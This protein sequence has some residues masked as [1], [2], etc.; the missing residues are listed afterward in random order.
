MFENYKVYGPYLRYDGRKHVVLVDKFTKK[1][2]TMSYPKYLYQI[3]HNVI[4]KDDQTIDHV[5][6][7]F[8][9]DSLDNLVV[10]S[11]VEHGKLDAR[12]V[13]L[14][15]IECV[16]CGAIAHK[17]ARYLTHSSRLG[18]AGPFCGKVCSGKYGASVQNGGKILP[19][20]DEVPKED[21]EYFYIEK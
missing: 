8:T 18:K 14:I 11:L 2:T 16:W 7:D 6:R 21:R 20:Q 1:K 3:T 5:D 9:N 4:L 15:K 12:R 17:K 10:R 19:M 13:K